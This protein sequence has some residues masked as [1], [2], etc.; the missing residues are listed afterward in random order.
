VSRRE[1]PGAAGRDR[2]G[3]GQ[4][5]KACCMVS[6]LLEES[7]IDREHIRRV[8]RQVLQGVILLCQWQLER[9]DEARE[10]TAAAGAAAA[11]KGRNISVE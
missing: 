8:R 1:K 7:G 6:E 4:P 11:R 2:E 10:R 3:S 9:M 5:R